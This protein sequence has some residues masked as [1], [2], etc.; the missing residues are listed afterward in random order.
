[1][2]NFFFFFF[3]TI[4]IILI[5]LTVI[6]IIPFNLIYS[7]KK[8][9]FEYTSYEYFFTYLNLFILL[10]AIS[11]S[12]YY[13]LSYLIIKVNESFYKYL[14]FFISFIFYWI[15][16][17]GLFLPLVGEA[18]PFFYLDYSI[19]LRYIFLIKLSLILLLSIYVTK[20]NYKN[21]ALRFTSTFL[22]LNLILNLFLTN[23]E[24]S[25]VKKNE[26]N[27]FGSNNL[28]VVSL[29]GVSGLKLNEEIQ[30]NIKFKEL[31]KDFKLY[32]NV[33]SSWPATMNSINAE[34][35]EKIIETNDNNLNENI[36]NDKNINIAVYNAYA[37][38]V[39]NKENAILRGTY[40]E[41]GKTFRTNSF[42]QN[43]LL[44]SVSRWGTPYLVPIL[45]KTLFSS[46]YKKLMRVISLE[47]YNEKNPF[48][49]VHTPYFVQMHEYDL[50]FSDDMIYNPAIKDTIRM[51]HFDFSHWPL[52]V[53]KDCE[54]IR[55]SN[56]SGYKQEAIAIK[57]LTKKI[58]SFIDALKKNNLYNN[59]LIIFKSDHGKP[60]GYYKDSPF[61][62][63]INDN[64]HWGYGRYKT[65]VMLKDKNKSKK[66]IEIS[67]KHVFLA[68]LAATYCNFFKEQNY[69]KK[70]YKGNNLLL[71]E[72]MFSDN[73]YE[74]Y[75]PNYNRA[76]LD[77]KG[78]TKYNVP[79]NESLLDSL[80]KTDVKLN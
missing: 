79:N 66:Q 36:L 78:F 45:T 3:F 49:F 75:L 7:E 65:F 9:L 44:P 62:I 18:D 23:S 57:C 24:Q 56:I 13:I 27:V 34:L 29:D 76:F 19:R 60:N 48:N 12:I 31:L 40:K 50:I 35:H 4:E 17:N 21:L 32:K 16:I 14:T 47:K 61:N 6:L 51:F 28:I 41:Y 59:S 46:N 20:F 5:N 80:K 30:N 68:D 37:K 1:M 11:L 25:I 22:I 70:K 63:K 10:C 42:F 8:L 33:T 52:R 54:E 64:R 69:C 53:T 72:K 15:M 43:V 74:I 26:I 2:R 67:N 77:M 55:E 39:N 58:S 73:S 38:F 71:P